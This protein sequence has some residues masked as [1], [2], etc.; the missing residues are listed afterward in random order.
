M[1]RMSRNKGKGG[2][3]EIAAKA[4]EHGFDARRGVQFQGGPD[5]PDVVGIP[6]WHAEVKRAESLSVY[7]AF[8]QAL[9][10]KGADAKPVV[11]H[12]RNGK[13]W[14]AILDADDFLSL[15][16]AQPSTE[17]GEARAVGKFD[18]EAA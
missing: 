8:E 15:V 2:E 10:D 9:A 16:K 18:A 4:R 17:R 13:R 12:R 5:S 11:F 3:R 7:P 14:L 6:G 1:G